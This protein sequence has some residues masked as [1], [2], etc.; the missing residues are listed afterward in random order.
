M[1]LTRFVVDMR[2]YQIDESLSSTPETFRETQIKHKISSL[3]DGSHTET[4]T[5]SKGTYRAVTEV[6]VSVGSNGNEWGSDGYIEIHRT[7]D[8]PDSSSKIAEGYLNVSS[9]VLIDE[10]LFSKKK[11]KIVIDHNAGT[12]KDVHLNIR[13]KYF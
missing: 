2:T 6:G 3:S 11:L 10:I 4:I 5:L 7:D 9:V 8:T 13:Y 12:A 1:A